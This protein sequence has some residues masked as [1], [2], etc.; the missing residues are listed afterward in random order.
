MMPSIR[1]EPCHIEL[2]SRG[3]HVEGGGDK[4]EVLVAT[5]RIG[6][7]A[8][9][10]DSCGT[11]IHCSVRPW[12]I[13]KASSTRLQ[14]DGE[15]AMRFGR[16]RQVTFSLPPISALSGVN[17]ECPQNATA[18]RGHAGTLHAARHVGRDACLQRVRDTETEQFIGRYRDRAPPPAASSVRSTPECS[19]CPNMRWT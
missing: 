17:N 11:V 16:L 8:S 5:R 13:C 7:A 12:S 19:S 3:L 14:T 6:C 2:V 9:S 10:P 15:I 4:P 1:V 18:P